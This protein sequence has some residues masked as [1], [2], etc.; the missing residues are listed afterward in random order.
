M[1]L[2]GETMRTRVRKWGNSLGIRIPN[3]IAQ[4]AGLRPSTEVE[5]SLDSGELRVALVH[6]TWRLDELLSKVTMRN[7]HAEQRL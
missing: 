5:V 6:A 4:E 3:P 2:E 1:K 7:L